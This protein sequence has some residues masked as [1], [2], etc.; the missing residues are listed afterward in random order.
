MCI[1]ITTGCQ[2][3]LKHPIRHRIDYRVL[4]YEHR[5]ASMPMTWLP[6]CPKPVSSSR[7]TAVL[8]RQSCSL[9][10]RRARLCEN[11]RTV[12]RISFSGCR[13]CY[14]KEN[15]WGDLGTSEPLE[16]RSFYPVILLKLTTVVKIITGMLQHSTH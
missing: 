4:F 10:F 5:I 7:I 6:D 15:N 3:V 14:S 2:T 1:S 13:P 16:V 11:S 12:H 9:V 8:T